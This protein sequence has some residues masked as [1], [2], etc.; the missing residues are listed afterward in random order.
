MFSFQAQL[1]VK[2]SINVKLLTVL[3][4]WVCKG[5]TKQNPNKLKR[6]KGWRHLREGIILFGLAEH[7]QK[8]LWRK[9]D[10]WKLGK[11]CTM[12]ILKSTLQISHFLK[13][14]MYWFT[15]LTCLWSVINNASYKSHHPLHCGVY[16]GRGELRK[17]CVSSN[18]NVWN[19]WNTGEFLLNSVFPILKSATFFYCSSPAEIFAS[20]RNWQ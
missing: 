17:F 5:K 20:K 12:Y 1:G 8:L 2:V 15:L 16:W 3:V 9:T 19:K 7:Y 14:I 10:F 18:G 11:L 6:G 4:Q 13:G